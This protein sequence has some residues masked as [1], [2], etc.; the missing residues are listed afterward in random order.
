MASGLPYFEIF[1]LV[2]LFSDMLKTAFEQLSSN[3]EINIV[4]IPPGVGA[5]PRSIVECYNIIVAMI[6]VVYFIETCILKLEI[7][8][9][10][11]NSCY[12]VKES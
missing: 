9:L 8:V 1:L 12:N 10:T 5:S 4:I 11:L 7:D 2:A 3:L 6:F